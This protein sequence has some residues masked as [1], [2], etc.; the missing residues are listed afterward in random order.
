[1]D[2][3]SN[4]LTKNISPEEFE[5]VQNYKRIHTRL[6]FLQK[7]MGEITKETQDLMQELDEMRKQD[8]K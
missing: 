8:K 3:N 2:I 7:Q 4:D 6:E 5:R 1:M